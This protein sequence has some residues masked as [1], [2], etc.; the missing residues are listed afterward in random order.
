MLPLTFFKVI[1]FFL[2]MMY[3]YCVA[4]FVYNRFLSS[5]RR[6]ESLFHIYGDMD[7]HAVFYL[8]Q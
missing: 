1:V 7:Q 6:A 3:N 8:I 5:S 2:P 4:I